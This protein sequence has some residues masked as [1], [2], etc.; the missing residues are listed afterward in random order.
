MPKKMGL[1]EEVLATKAIP[2]KV[3]GILSALSSIRNAMFLSSRGAVRRGSD[4]GV[5]PYSFPEGEQEALFFGCKER[6]LP[7]NIIA[8]RILLFYSASLCICR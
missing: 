5:V 3:S 4:P 7:A 8:F 1:G 6:F 2:R